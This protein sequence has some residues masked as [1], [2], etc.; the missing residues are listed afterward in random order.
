MRGLWRLLR[1][2]ALLLLTSAPLRADEFKPAYLQLTQV[3]SETY[4]I[5]WK[6][7]AIDEFTTTQ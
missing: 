4:D 7:P 5:L 6:I 3:E 1:I 2:A